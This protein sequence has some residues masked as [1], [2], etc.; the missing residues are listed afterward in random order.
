M[1]NPHESFM[2]A[3]ATECR[4]MSSTSPLPALQARRS[5]RLG[6][7]T[8]KAIQHSCAGLTRA[9]RCQYPF[10]NTRRRYAD[11]PSNMYSKHSSARIK[12]L[13][14]AASAFGFEFRRAGSS[15]S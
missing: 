2:Q 11:G 9:G 8:G 10:H 5:L 6:L 14:I 15:E 7:G 3:R 1:V 4:R 12:A 13:V